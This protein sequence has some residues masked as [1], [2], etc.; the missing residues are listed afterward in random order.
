MEIGDWGVTKELNEIYQQARDL[1]LESSPASGSILLTIF[2]ATTWTR[3]K[4]FEITS[5]KRC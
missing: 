5:R 2:V 3:R 1:G 4:P